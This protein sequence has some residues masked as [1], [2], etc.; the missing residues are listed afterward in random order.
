MSVIPD[1]SGQD[2]VLT[3]EL[4]L[5]LH[6]KV[7]NMFKSEAIHTIRQIKENSQIPDS[8]RTN[9]MNQIK[10]ACICLYSTGHN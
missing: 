2:R 10:S 1:A 9:V 7:N 3:L 8:I 4:P 6:G 5:K